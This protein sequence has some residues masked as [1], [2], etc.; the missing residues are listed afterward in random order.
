MDNITIS[1]DET[2]H[3]ID[4]KPLYSNR[5]DNVQNFHFPPGL[6]PVKMNQTAYFITLTGEKV[7]DRTF[8]QA[9]GFYE[10]IATVA[11]ES[12]FFHVDKQGQDIH[13]LR[14][15]WSGNFQE[16]YCAVQDKKTKRF[17]HINRQAKQVYQ[18]QYTY[19]GDYKYSIAVAVNENGLSTH[20]DTKG[21]LI[22]EKFFLELDVYHKGYAIAKDEQGYFHIDKQGNALYSNRFSK[23]EPFYNGRAIA[24]DH[25]NVKKI[26]SSAGEIIQIIDQKAI[27][28]KRIKTHFAHLAFDY[29]HSR[30]LAAILELAIL[31]HFEKP[32]PRS[33]L[34]QTIDLPP[35]SVDMI[36]R[37]L[38]HQ[39]LVELK[40]EDYQLTL[41]GKTLQ[42]IKQV[43]LYWQSPELINTSLSLADSLQAHCEYF[44]RK[45][46]LTFFEHAK[47][48]NHINL[49][50]SSVMNFYAI[51]YQKH[52]PFLALSQEIVIDIGGGNGVLLEKI[53][54]F[55][56]QITPIILDKYSYE[57]QNNFTLIK[58]DF[59]QPWFVKA[60]VYILSRVLHD[61]S[62]EQVVQILSNIANNMDDLSVLYIFETVINEGD[63]TDKGV[64]ISF[65]LLNILGGRE[66]TLIE[67]WAL[68]QCAGLTIQQYY[69]L[70]EI[71]SLMKVQRQ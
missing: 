67:F 23:L 32:I 26:I 33:A 31:D 59:F 69:L 48:N 34:Y 6:A 19:V 16:G 13:S 41:S 5:F 15:E 28:I 35:K 17:F 43:F 29:W 62:D 40:T 54:K 2:H 22:H 53:K 66:R 52:L 68:F 56:P 8:K 60:D 25:N 70:D 12:G 45:H 50:L 3:L 7:F 55:Y 51:D 46:Q 65:H 37:W 64:S 42:Q 4:D 21:K 58:T 30:I 11:D 1:L 10:G 18:E 63:E 39:C 47:Q 57:R 44:S 61:W 24:I 14:F 49:Q 38:L 36:I 27:Q 20:I 71:I 9:F